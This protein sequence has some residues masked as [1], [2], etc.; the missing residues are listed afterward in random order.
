MDI[1]MLI[2]GDA[3]GGRRRRDL[4][5]ATIPFTGKVAT[6]ARRRASPTPTPRS[7]PR[8]PPSRPGR[9]SAPTSAASS[10]SRR[11]TSCEAKAAN[12]PRLVIEE[13]GATRPWGG[14][15]VML[16]ANMLR[17]AAAMTT[18]ITGEVI[19]SDKPGT[20]RHGDAPAGRRG[21][22]ASRPGTRRSSSACAR[23]AMPL[24]CGNTV[25]LK[26]S[27]LCPGTHRLIG[28]AL[29]RGRPAEG[30]R[31]CRHQRAGR[32]GRRSSRR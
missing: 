8:R 10:C 32:R 20:H 12:S 31:Q 15:N 13:T 5:R 3:I 19:P 6:G 11:P 23:I 4:R 24:A 30:R 28:E 29:H 21:A 18:Q 9:R 14:F 22:S 25:V 1:R 17:E 27:E 7:T 2:N 26:A 16:A